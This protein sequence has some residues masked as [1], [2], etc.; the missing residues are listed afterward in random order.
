MRFAA[1]DCTLGLH[2]PP[3]EVRGISKRARRGHR[4]NDA[5][6]VRPETSFAPPAHHPTQQNGELDS[7][8]APR[9]RV[10]M[11][12]FD[13]NTTAPLEF[14]FSLVQVLLQ[15]YL[16]AQFVNYVLHWQG[17]NWL[18]LRLYT[19]FVMVLCSTQ[20]AFEIY[21]AKV[22]V[23]SDEDWSH[24]ALRGADLL[25]N[26][27]VSTLVQG[28]FVLRCWKATHSIRLGVFLILL[29]SAQFGFIIYLS[30]VLRGSLDDMEQSGGIIHAH[31]GI[32][33]PETRLVVPFLIAIPTVLDILMTT[34][35][36][37]FFR[38]S[39]T[40]LPPLD[41]LLRQTSYLA[42]ESAA[43]PSI[44]RFIGGIAY[45]LNHQSWV[46]VF[47]M[48]TGKLYVKSYLRALNVRPSL[49]RKA[50]A[51]RGRDTIAC[52]N[53]TTEG[54]I[55]FTSPWS[56]PSSARTSEAIILPHAIPPCRPRSS[57]ADEENTLSFIE[58][59]Q[60]TVPPRGRRRSS[61]ATFVWPFGSD[62][63]KDPPP[64]PSKGTRLEHIG[65]DVER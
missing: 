12:Y 16:L 52:D 30:L 20:T 55:E 11:V 46:I 27:S 57:P 10:E 50:Q 21:K 13:T 24:N 42:F 48:I 33:S 39:Q 22:V 29:L 5:S 64:S 1:P 63:D 9:R 17:D 44:A 37:T 43:V 3:P 40:G 36:V 65:E 25:C 7:V 6:D 31:S 23:L 62:A 49:R 56:A 41:A 35:L 2:A 54:T 58:A 8:R 61:E 14:A 32:A 4:E 47:V 53:Y 38:R 34:I 51:V 18:G 60:A 19:V 26:F 28:F 45:L 59:L 15:G